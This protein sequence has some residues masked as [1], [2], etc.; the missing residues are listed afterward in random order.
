MSNIYKSIEYP[1]AIVEKDVFGIIINNTPIED[2]MK[3]LLKELPEDKKYICC[4][5][6]ELTLI[7]PDK[8]IINGNEFKKEQEENEKKLIEGYKEVIEN[9]SI[10]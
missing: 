7:D 4:L 9:E 8:T 2:V 5:N 6:I 3:N 10:H 1:A